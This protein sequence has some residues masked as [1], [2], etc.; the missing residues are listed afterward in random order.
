M[1]KNKSMNTR[2]HV[3][4]PLPAALTDVTNSPEN[5]YVHD[6]IFFNS[7]FIILLCRK[8]LEENLMSL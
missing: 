2:V 8:K 1:Q 7:G 3:F 6:L 4:F 5:I